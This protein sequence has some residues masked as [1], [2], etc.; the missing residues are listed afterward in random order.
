VSPPVEEARRELERRSGA[1]WEIYAKEAEFRE[2]RTSAAGVEEADR[3]EEGLAARWAQDGQALFAAASSPA[4]LLAQIAA[5]EPA[6]P[7]R[8]PRLPQ[9][10][11]GRYEASTE[12]AA[13]ALAVDF[14]ALSQLLSAESKGGVRLSALTVT[15]GFVSERIENGVGLV[16]ERRRGYGHGRAHAVGGQGTRRRT[17]SLVF[18]WE[19]AGPAAPL[20]KIAQRLSDRCLIPLRGGPAPVSRGELLLDPEVAA[21]LVSA[22]LPLFCGD[23]RRTLLSKRYLDRTGR[24]AAEGISLIDDATTQFACDGEGSPV[25]RNVVVEDGVFQ[26]RLHDLSSA[27]RSG[28]R[29]TGNG[30]RPSFRVPPEAG[31]SRF[32][33]EARKAVAPLDLL[34][35]V[36]RGI[37]AT[38]PA[39]PVRVELDEDR[40]RLEIEG[41]ALQAGRARAPVSRAIVSGR[42]SD[43]LRGLAAAGNDRRWFLQSTL[44]GA[45][46]LYL[47]RVSFT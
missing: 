27:A 46:T 38:A 4:L 45:P 21:A 17:A 20:Q 3:R 29:P 43:L 14:D 6:A 36:A 7:G 31:S 22:L 33:L 9:L 39:A 25:R 18:P 32:F 11:F 41:W 47:P 16:G 10:P 42:L 13:P 23:A 34:A 35:G 26:A 44:I 15:S 28:E 37:Y 5:A 8:P 1:L 19:D 40:F 30:W 2:I 12:A 24:F